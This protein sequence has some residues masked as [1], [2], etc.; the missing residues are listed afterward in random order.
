MQTL[1]SCYLCDL[2]KDLVGNKAF[3]IVLIYISFNLHGMKQ[4]KKI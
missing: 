4:L 1:L 3:N 2:Q